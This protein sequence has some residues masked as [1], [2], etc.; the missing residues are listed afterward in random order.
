MSIET[1]K[2]TIIIVPA[3]VWHEV[4]PYYG[5]ED[6]LAVVMNISFPAR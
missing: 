4:T 2:N 6:R 1:E 3:H 5:E